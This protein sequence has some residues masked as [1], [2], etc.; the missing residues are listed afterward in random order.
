MHA[1]P[2]WRDIAGTLSCFVKITISVDI[3]RLFENQVWA[4]GLG[5]GHGKKRHLHAHSPVNF[6]ASKCYPNS[7]IQ[8]GQEE[9]FNGSDR[10]GGS[11]ERTGKDIRRLVAY[12]S[13]TDNIKKANL[14]GRII[15]DGDGLPVLDI[16]KTI[17]KAV[18]KGFFRNQT[19]TLQK[20]RVLQIQGV[21]GAAVVIYRKPLTTLDMRCHP[22]SR[23]VTNM[24]AFH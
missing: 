20:S 21:K 9:A 16:D 24:A 15:L 1:S 10:F 6:K 19:L 5:Q 22:L 7:G 8:K 2:P 12:T 13:I 18:E 4:R 17:R 14:L 11:S 3:N 23:R